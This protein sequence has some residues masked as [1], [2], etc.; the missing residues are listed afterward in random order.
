[1]PS[2]KALA[3]AMA[4]AASG[5]QATEIEL[6]PC[7]EPF[8][9]YV[10]SGCFKDLGS[11]SILQWRTPL[12]QQAMTAELCRPNLLWRLLLWTNHQRPLGG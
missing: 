8:R 7:L 6:P 3:A 4:L 10:Y 9:P 1:M 2:L 12:D 5:I 11:P